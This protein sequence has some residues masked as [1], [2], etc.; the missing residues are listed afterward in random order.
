[1]KVQFRP[2][3]RSGTGAEWVMRVEEWDGEV[4]ESDLHQ[5]KPEHV[6]G[7]SVLR[8]VRSADRR[9]FAMGRTASG[10]WVS[11]PLP[12]EGISDDELD[13]WASNPTNRGDYNSVP[14]LRPLTP[15]QRTLAIAEAHIRVNTSPGW[16][17]SAAVHQGARDVLAGRTPMADLNAKLMAH[18]PTGDKAAA[19]ARQGKGFE[20]FASE[21]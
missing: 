5:A 11:W 8:V 19:A 3:D 10:R 2:V 20:Q 4:T 1:M 15:E 13:A 12:A 21:A 17:H 6:G 9:K 14:A 16:I 7:V 18:D